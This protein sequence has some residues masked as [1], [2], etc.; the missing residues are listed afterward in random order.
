MFKKILIANRGEIALRV[1]RTCRDLGIKTVA[2][3]STIDSESMHVR[4]ADEA[5]CIGEPSIKKSYLNPVPILAAAEITNADAVHPGAGFLSENPDFA[6]MVAKHKMTFIGPTS[7]QIKMFGDKLLAKKLM[8]KNGLTVIPGSERYL[9][10][11]EEAKSIAKK[12]GYPVI[13]KA[14]SG[15]GGKGI[16]V[17]KNEK[18]LIPSY[19]LVKQ[20]VQNSFGNENIY[21]EKFFENPKHIEIQIIGDKKGKVV[22]L[23]ERDCSIQR[24]RQKIIEETP[25]PILSEKERNYICNLVVKTIKKIRYESLGTVEM[26]YKNGKFYFMEMN[27]RVQIEHTIT[28]RVTGIDLIKQQIKIAAGQDI[29]F[30]QKDIR[31]GG[32]SI[33]CRINAEDPLTFIPSPGRI[34]EYHAPGGPGV[35]IDSALYAGCIVPH[36]YDNLISK[37]II[38][39]RNRNEAILR[40]KRCLIEYVINGIKTNIPLHLKILNN[41]DY[42]SGNYHINWLEQFL[43]I[44]N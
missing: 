41:E 2:V 27:T 13:L 23:G 33:Q 19:S 15:G 31:N 39:S 21:L 37:V 32:H 17:I 42:I 3:Y 22:H 7:E 28:E 4:L 43:S 16:R 1:V 26:L 30:D 24:N 14:G 44:Q 25:S 34:Q 11:I 35:R 40:L 5:V 6:S 8:K 10:N 36:H 9:K 20:E 18:N 12:I 29:K 38:Y